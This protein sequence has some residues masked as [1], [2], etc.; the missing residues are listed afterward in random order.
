LLETIYVKIPSLDDK[1]LVPTLKDCLNKAEHPE[2]IHLGVSLIY[3]NKD[4]LNELI[5]FKNQYSN[6]NIKIV[7]RE[8][9]INYLGVG[10]Q[11][12]IVGDMF[13]DQDYVLQIDSHTWFCDNWDTKLINLHD[14]NPTTILTAYAGE[15]GYVDG[16]RKPIGDGRLRFPRVIEGDRQFV[17]FT[18]AWT[19]EV[20]DSEE[21]FIKAEKFCAN[22]AFGTKEWGVRTGLAAESVFWSEE[23]LQTEYLQLNKFNLV[24][25]NVDYPLICHLY[26]KHITKESERE[27]FTNYLEQHQ[28]DYLMNVYD[29]EVYHSH[30]NRITKYTNIQE[31][32]TFIENPSL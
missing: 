12:K 5:A 31:N 6:A 22:F 28:V 25:P 1:E 19:A 2:R 32:A 27:F 24:F 16:V 20:I 11:R 13:D 26:A 21:D 7:T 23:P 17:N 10:K 3:K 18:D 29:E 14:K 9:D 4:R 15:Y 8:L 30:M